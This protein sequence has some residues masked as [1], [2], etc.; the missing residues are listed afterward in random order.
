MRLTGVPQQLP[1]REQRAVHDL[2]G[3]HGGR[4]ALVKVAPLLVA[5]RNLHNFKPDFMCEYPGAGACALTSVP[6]QLSEREQR[7]VHDLQRAHGGRATLV[8]VAP[9]LVRAQRL[10]RLVEERVVPDHSVPRLALFHQAKAGL[11]WGS[12]RAQDQGGEL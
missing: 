1:E 10:L 8:W 12:S 11:Q 3:A 9:L 4:A 6:Q 2:Q 7:A 5:P